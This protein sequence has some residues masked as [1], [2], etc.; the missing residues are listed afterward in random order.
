MHDDGIW[1]NSNGRGHDTPVGKKQQQA[2]KIK[3]LQPGFSFWR[4]KT[5]PSAFLQINCAAL[6]RFDRNNSTMLA[7]ITATSETLLKRFSDIV[8]AEAQTISLLLFITAETIQ[9]STSE[10]RYV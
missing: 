1:I 3:V 7:I 5:S 2:V 8:R 4:Q 9:L 10:E 6:Q